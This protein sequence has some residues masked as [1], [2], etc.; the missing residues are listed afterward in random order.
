[1][2]IDY[3]I[4]D[5]DGNSKIFLFVKP[6]MKLEFWSSAFF[7]ILAKQDADTQKIELTA[8]WQDCVD[9]NALK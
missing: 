1:M 8:T 6:C 3:H 9:I 5:R 2:I 4:N 7:C